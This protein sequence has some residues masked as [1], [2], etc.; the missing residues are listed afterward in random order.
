[1]ALLTLYQLSDILAVSPAFIAAHTDPERD[2]AENPNSRTR[3]WAISSGGAQSVTVFSKRNSNFGP[4]PDYVFPILG[5]SFTI[6]PAF[7]ASRF[8][9][10]DGTIE[11]LFDTPGQITIASVEDFSVLTGTAP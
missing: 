7:N 1:M 6:L 3:I 8:N 10:L 2:K 4:Y 9:D 11:F 5:N